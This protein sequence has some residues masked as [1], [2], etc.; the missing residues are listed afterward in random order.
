MVP[1]FAT[2]ENIDAQVKC[3]CAPLFAT[4][5]FLQGGHGESTVSA[6]VTFVK[7]ESHIYA[8]TCHHVLSAFL[9]ASVTA[10]QRLVPSIHSG[11][12]VHQFGTYGPDQTYIW[13]FVSCRE[14]PKVEDITNDDDVSK[15]ALAALDRKN[16]DKPDIAIAD[17]TAVWEVMSK[18]RNAEAIDLDAWVEPKWSEVQPV[19]LA[20]GF[21]DNHKYLQGDK[22][23]A[24][25]PRVTAELATE[26]PGESDKYILCSTLGAEHGWGFSGMSGG[27]VFVA[28]T[29][30]DRYAF[31]GITFEGAPS[32]KEL[33]G[34]REAFV[35]K[36]DI[37]LRGYHVTPKRFREWLTRRDYGV[38]FS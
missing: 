7:F 15:T 4:G 36:N 33:D 24:P 9:T 21:P 23:V 25:M 30:E 27:P 16:A 19:W 3:F 18:Q 37:L 17:V 35:R 5:Q 1:I 32:S 31:V 8:V 14:F 6:T 22:V 34:N 10:G 12:V 2:N 28:H 20:Y 38:K 13:A 26:P 11:K 29:T